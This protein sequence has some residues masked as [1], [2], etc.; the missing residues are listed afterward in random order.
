MLICV[1]N[2][3]TVMFKD[4]HCKQYLKQSIT[5][6]QNLKRVNYFSGRDVVSEQ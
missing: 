2:L 6:R 5:D 4:T 1:Q 3:I